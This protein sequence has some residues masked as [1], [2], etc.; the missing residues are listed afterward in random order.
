MNSRWSPP[1]A[2]RLPPAPD[3]P[4]Q[5]LH[6]GPVRAARRAGGGLLLELLARADASSDPDAGLRRALPKALVRLHGDPEA[7]LAVLRGRLA[8][9][10]DPAA[11]RAVV[12]ALGELAARRAGSAA[13][14]AAVDVLTTLLTPAGAGPGAGHAAG[15][16]PAGRVR[17]A[18]RRAAGDTPV[19][20]A[21]TRRPHGGGGRGAPAGAAPPGG[22]A[23][24]VRRLVGRR[25]G[26]RPVA[27]GGDVAESL[28][29]LSWAWE[30]HDDNRPGVAV[31]WAEMGPAAASAVRVLRRE[32]A[33]VR[34]HND[35]G[36]TGRM[37]YHCAG[38]E[39]L[40]ARARTALEACGARA[41]GAAVLGSR[42]RAC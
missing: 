42:T 36:G 27:G 6:R 41:P 32:V 9:E 39:L 29:V 7:V 19:P 11:L 18:H 12:A 23:G 28:P 13:A 25:S 21:R 4:A 3:F 8:V 15:A 20:G 37:R 2:E 40:L 10:D 26:G 35:T 30:E 34:R 22:R 17:R 14:L 16:G 38:D 24:G 5:G 1:D 33:A 31:A